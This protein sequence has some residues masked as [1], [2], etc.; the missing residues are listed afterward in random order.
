VIRLPRKCGASTYHN[1]LALH[2]LLQRQLYLT[3]LLWFLEWS[4]T[5]ST[6]GTSVVPAQVMDDY[7]GKAVGVMIG[8]GN[9]S[10]RR[11][12][13]SLPLCPPQ[14]PYDPTWART[15]AVTVRTQRLTGLSYGAPIYLTLLKTLPSKRNLN[16]KR[17]RIIAWNVE[18]V[19]LTAFIFF[20]R[21]GNGSSLNNNKKV[22]GLTM[23]LSYIRTESC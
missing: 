22:H 18:C 12:P 15:R 21:T 10:T 11:K 7:E 14:I 17:C 4:E 5:V 13:A 8:R 1:V 20:L 19:Q 16:L 3:L 6:L 2:G 9:R 23:S